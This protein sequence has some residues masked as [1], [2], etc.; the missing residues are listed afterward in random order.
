MT[1]KPE[2]QTHV[3]EEPEPI[4]ITVVH[5]PLLKR[6]RRFGPLIVGHLQAIGEVAAAWTIL[7]GI[8]EA[9]IWGFLKLPGEEARS[10]TAK[11]WIKQRLETLGILGHQKLET[12]ASKNQLDKMLTNISK[13]LERDRNRIIHATWGPSVTTPLHAVA[14]RFLPDRDD[15]TKRRY[16]RISSDDKL[17]HEISDIATRILDM[18]NQL[19]DFLRAHNVY[20]IP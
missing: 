18:C 10:F 19:E 5:D 6:K 8:V 14:I 12:D 1:S 9:G 7:E 11:M 17:S 13:K 3:S 16:I 4:E 15:N 2:N 20:G